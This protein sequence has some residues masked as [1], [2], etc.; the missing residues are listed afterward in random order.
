MN[1]E[2]LTE[3]GL[4][5]GI[6]GSPQAATRLLSRFGS[7]WRA[8][9]AG[10][11]RIAEEG[12]ITLR[13]ARQLLAGLEL[14]RLAARASWGQERPFR[15]AADVAAAYGPRLA[16]L[17]H[18]RFYALSLDAKNRRIGE[19][20]VAR[21]SRAECR[22]SP[23]DAFVGA[24]RDGAV[25]ILFLHNHPSGDPSPSPEDYA[26]TERLRSVG[27]LLEIPMLDHII[28]GREGFV[29]FTEGQA[30]GS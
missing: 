6:L 16:S 7:I 3:L 4:L 13:Q 29:S 23:R 10:S 30:R 2:Q 17:D 20:L 22:I 1:Q 18:E 24:L 28:L 14:G 25:S 19:A 8:E 27:A 5:S 15:R 26:L 21:G 11:V 9:R 12:G